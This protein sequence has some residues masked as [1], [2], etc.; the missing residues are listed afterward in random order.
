MEKQRK[1]VTRIH[2]SYLSISTNGTGKFFL[3]CESPTFLMVLSLALKIRRE[4]RWKEEK[5]Q[6]QLLKCDQNSRR[7]IGSLFLL[8]YC[9]HFQPFIFPKW[10]TH[11]EELTARIDS[12]SS[13]TFRSIPTF[14]ISLSTSAV[15]ALQ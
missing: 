1:Q 10:S 11:L 13:R 14:S 2:Q 8:L 4:T 12:T 9:Y 15:D 6:L 3:S 7:G 5:W